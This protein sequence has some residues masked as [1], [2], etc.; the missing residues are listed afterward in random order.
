MGSVLQEW[1]EGIPRMQQSVLL[2]AIRGPD[3]LDKKHP[4]KHL[5][6]W[7]RRCILLSAFDGEALL[8][9]RDPRGGSFTGPMPSEY[10]AHY[11][12]PPH[13]HLMDEDWYRDRDAETISNIATAYIQ[14]MDSIPLHAYLH[15]MHA[16]EIVGYRHPVEWIRK[17]W[18]DTYVR[19]AEKMHLW[20]ESEQQ[21]DLRLG[22]VE[23]NWRAREDKPR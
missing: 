20:P 17:S 23:S 2:S 14:S 11:G 9:P 7:L 13:G 5:V 16:A 10:R 1:V 18:N 8:D 21:L 22:D 19:M 4:S 6:V 3:G 12:L 15:L